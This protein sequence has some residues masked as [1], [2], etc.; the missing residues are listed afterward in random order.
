MKLRPSNGRRKT[1]R[2]STMPNTDSTAMVLPCCHIHQPS[3]ERLD[4]SNDDD[5]SS[6]DRTRE[7]E[8]ISPFGPAL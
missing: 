7:K 5:A 4:H 1:I 2:L 6:Q 8:T 3:L